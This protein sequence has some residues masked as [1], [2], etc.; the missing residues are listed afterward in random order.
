MFKRTS[1]SNGLE[2]AGLC[3]HYHILFFHYFLLIVPNLLLVNVQLFNIKRSFKSLTQGK[4]L[5]TQKNGQFLYFLAP[6]FHW[7][8]FFHFFVFY[9]FSIAK[10]VTFHQLFMLVGCHTLMYLAWNIEREKR[11]VEN[12]LSKYLLSFGSFFRGIFPP[13]TCG[14]VDGVIS[15]HLFI[16]C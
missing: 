7:E 4:A 15:F 16:S 11:D 6:F 10:G 2:T 14:H 9:S 5:H 3:C 12:N 13:H 1:L 8:L